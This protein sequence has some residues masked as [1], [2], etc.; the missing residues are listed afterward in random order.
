MPM[1]RL[2]PK[3]FNFKM[4][5]QFPNTFNLIITIVH[6]I[7]MIKRVHCSPPQYF[8]IMAWCFMSIRCWFIAESNDN[9]IRKR[10]QN[11]SHGYCSQMYLF[12]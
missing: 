6:D 5:I 12:F 8:A 2:I 7:C 1:N 9:L 11:D 4:M 10:S 3:Q